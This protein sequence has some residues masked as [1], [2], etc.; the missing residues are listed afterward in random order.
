METILCS[1]SRDRISRIEV[2]GKQLVLMNALTNLYEG[3]RLQNRFACIIYAFAF[4]VS[5]GYRERNE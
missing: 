1:F 4:L 2:I 5:G 3:T